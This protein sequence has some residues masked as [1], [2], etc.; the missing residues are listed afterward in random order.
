MS[1]K[2][3]KNEALRKIYKDINDGYLYGY[4]DLYFHSLF[5]IHEMD[6]ARL[7]GWDDIFSHGIVWNT[8]KDLYM[9]ITKVY[10]TTPEM[11]LQTYIRSDQSK[12]Y[13]GK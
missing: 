11:F 12:Y 2:F 1:Q 6:S 10:K 5:W 9:L 13:K 3:Y 7:D 8:L 4:D